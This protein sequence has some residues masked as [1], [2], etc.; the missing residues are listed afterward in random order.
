MR[1]D[2]SISFHLSK[3]SIAK[4]SILYDISLVRDWRRKLK[5][6]TLGSERVKVPTLAT[7]TCILDFLLCTQRKWTNS[8]SVTKMWKN[9]AFQTGQPRRLK[10]TSEGHCRKGKSYQRRR[11]LTPTVLRQVRSWTLCTLPYPRP[12]LT[13]ANEGASLLHPSCVPFEVVLHAICGNTASNHCGNTA[14]NVAIVSSGT[15]YTV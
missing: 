9:L 1:N 6:I 15:V 7:A 3:L 2:C 11:D 14:S 10:T 4:F 5:L 12:L 13:V 8:R